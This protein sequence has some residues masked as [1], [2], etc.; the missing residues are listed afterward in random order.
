MTEWV[1]RASIRFRLLMLIAAAVVFAVAVGVFRDMSVDVLPEYSPT[2][3]EVQTE[4]LGLSAAEVEQFITV[5]LEGDLLNG[6]PW[7]KSMQSESMPGVSTV[8][9]LFEPGTDELRARQVVNERITQ[10]KALPNV[11]SPPVMLEPRSSNSRV[12]MVAMKPTGMSLIDASVLARYTIR[13]KLMSVPGVA[14]VLLW[15]QRDQQLQVLLDPKRLADKDVTLSQ[16][17]ETAGNAMWVSPLSFLEASSPGAGGFVETANQRV[18]I[19]HVQPI[20]SPDTLGQISI[21]D[22]PGNKV[23]LSDVST[24]VDGFPPLIGDTAADD[25]AALML[26]VEKFPGANPLEVTRGVE[27]A[28]QDLRPG[29]KG[30][31]LDSSYFRPAS[32]LELAASD[33]GTWLLIGAVLAMLAIGLLLFSWRAA[34]VSVVAVT[35]SLATAVIALH[36]LG[37]TANAVVLAGL[38]AAVTVLVDDA[39]LDVGAIRRGL[40]DAPAGSDTGDVVA[41]ASL[42]VRSAV[43]YAVAAGLLVVLPV[44]VL[45]GQQRALYSPLVIAYA[46]AVAASTIVALT[47]TPALCTLLLRGDRAVLSERHPLR[48]LTGL[49]AGAL[50][51]LLGKPRTVLVAGVVVLLVGLATLPLLSMGSRLLPAMRDPNVLVQ[52]VAPP[53]TSLGEVN[54]ISTKAVS[55]IRRVPGVRHVGAQ[56]G[57]AVLGDQSVNVDSSELWVTLDDSADYDEALSSMRSIVAGYPGIVGKVTTYEQ[58]QAENILGPSTHD[59]TVRVYGQDQAVLAAK[60]DE[61]AR[62]MHDV[63]GV[64]DPKVAQQAKQP[65]L[66]IEPNIE[67]A[68]KVGIKPGDIRRSAST[69]VEGIAVGSLFKDQKVFDVFVRGVPSAQHSVAEVQNLLVDTPDGN[70]VRLGDVAGVRIEPRPTVIHHTDV[71]RRIDVTATVRGRSVAAASSDVAARLASVQFPLEHHA[72]VLGDYAEARDSDLSVLAVSLAALVGLYLLL[73]GAFG[74]WRLAGAVFLALPVALAGALITSLAVGT[75]TLGTLAGMLAVLALAVRHS[76]LYVRHAQRLRGAGDATG[77][78]EAGRDFGPELALD[79]ARERF[80]PVLTTVVA[81]GLALVPVLLLGSRPGLEIVQPLT[82][83]VLGGLL[84]SAFVTLVLVPAAYLAFGSGLRGHGGDAIVED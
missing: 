1:V 62:L 55:E 63:P 49:Y 75:V 34:A 21:Q 67:L 61:I 17:V 50:P 15:G 53:G 14:N 66:I 56:S 79:A 18:G 2:E 7:L 30:L 11:S 41:G 42:T 72:E 13:P 27:Q 82:V 74:S 45:G 52:F 10:A 44:L 35:L 29:L 12:L 47:V 68:Q 40:H 64:V 46:I 83:A 19:Q 43:L 58:R 5:P 36:V 31:D 48:R 69:L 26:V 16:V 77:G 71:S 80:G 38:V 20:A 70:Q 60:A 28:I 78:A 37:A 54:R 51:R 73:Q 3:V 84:T 59:I 24:I 81:V 6:V 22:S 4:A 65:T 57:R 32:Y 25:S 39:V 76:V 33:I 8:T 23:R 9:L